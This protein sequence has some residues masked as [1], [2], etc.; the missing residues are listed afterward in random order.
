MENSLKY[1]HAAVKA[2]DN[3][4]RSLSQLQLHHRKFS[5]S[6]H[7]A[8]GLT[9]VQFHKLMDEYKV[10]EYQQQG[11]CGMSISVPYAQG[12]GCLKKTIFLFNASRAKKYDVIV[13][14]VSSSIGFYWKGISLIVFC[15]FL[16]S[17]VLY[18]FHTFLG[19]TAAGVCAIIIATIALRYREP[20]ELQDITTGFMI[21]QLIDAGRLV[22]A[23]EKFEVVRGEN[24]G[25]LQ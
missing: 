5:L 13:A 24:H 2:F 21:Q 4:K 18:I 23:G 22:D 16:V 19:I 6:Y 3:Y 17:T 9:K 11:S 20:V 1:Q 14:E 25:I 10:P 7:D 15:S 12:G 8:C